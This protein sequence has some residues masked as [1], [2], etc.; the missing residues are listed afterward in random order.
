[1]GPLPG[2]QLEQHHPQRIEIAACVGRGAGQQ[3]GRHVGRCAQHQA[4]ARAVPVQQARGAEV[5]DLDALRG[6]VD[7]H[8]GGLDVAVDD[9]LRVRMGQRAGHPGASFQHHPG[10]QEQ[11][12]LGVAVQAAARCQLHRQPQPAGRFARFEH[13]HDVRV[14]HPLHDGGFLGEALVHLLAIDLGGLPAR[15][16]HLDGHPARVA[17][18]LAPGGRWRWSPCPGRGPADRYPAGVCRWVSS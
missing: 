6:Q 7:Q 12:G 14:L 17:F 9:T 10:W 4:R 5:R 13:G 1:V 3:L 18:V 11:P 8:I 15:G 2:Q 16:Q